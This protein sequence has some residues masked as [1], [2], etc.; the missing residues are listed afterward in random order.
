MIMSKKNY[1]E[2]IENS[3]YSKEAKETG[4]RLYS[5]RTEKRLSMADVV[6]RVESAQRDE[7]KQVK[8]SKSQYARYELGTAFINTEVVYA[9]CEFY[10]TSPDFLLLGKKSTGKESGDYDI[11]NLISPISGENLQSF[12]DFLES[13]A[14]VLRKIAKDK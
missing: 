1:K 11:S 14:N 5:L 6:A 10:H 7:D 8:L 12:C 9:L 2:Q 3:P 4:S 13:L